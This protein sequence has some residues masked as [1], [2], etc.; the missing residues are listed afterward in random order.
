M[1][2]PMENGAPPENTAEKRP[3]EATR[4][5]PG[6]PGRPKG[7]RSKLG[8]DF[9]KA[10]QADF[11]A[12]GVAAIATVRE[13]KPEVYVKVIASIL[14]KEIDLSADLSISSKE[15]RDAAVA[16]FKRVIGEPNQEAMH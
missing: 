16:A 12:N 10:L 9:L 15:Q 6:N 1:V 13:T 11:A 7:A 4:F 2:C 8:E 3:G 14:P 5:K